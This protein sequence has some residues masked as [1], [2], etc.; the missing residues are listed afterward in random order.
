MRGNSDSKN[1]E[2]G[3]F[4]HSAVNV[5]YAS[6]DRKLSSFSKLLYV[7]SPLVEVRSK[8]SIIPWDPECCTF[9]CSFLRHKLLKTWCDLLNLTVQ[10][11]SVYIKILRNIF[12]RLEVWCFQRYTN[13]D[14]KLSSYVRVPMKIIPWKFRILN[15]KNS[16]V[17]YLQSCEIFAYKHT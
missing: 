4:S 3:H 16:R 1:S 14:L 5:T 10:R 9:N 7:I 17:I 13:A 6:K 12:C 8:S 15:R 11:S 2:Y